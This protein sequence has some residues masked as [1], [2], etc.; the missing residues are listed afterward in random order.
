MSTLTQN[1]AQVADSEHAPQSAAMLF[2]ERYFQTGLGPPYDRNEYWL[3]FFNG[4]AEHITRSLNPHRVLDAGCAMG[5][6]V[7]AFWDRGAEAWGIDISP[8]AIARVR[9][10]IISGQSLA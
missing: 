3:G 4:I 1:R 5:M 7:E 2:D 6:L 8:Y 10:D 9:P